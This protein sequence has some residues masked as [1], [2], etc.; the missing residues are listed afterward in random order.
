MKQH[1]RLAGFYILVEQYRGEQS[2]PFMEQL[3]K[4]SSQQFFSCS[5]GLTVIVASV[6]H[7]YCSTPVVQAASNDKAEE[8]E[9]A[10]LQTLFQSLSSNNNDVSI[11][12]IPSV[13]RCGLPYCSGS[14]WAIF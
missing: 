14:S 3:L 2:N 8:V 7:C 13:I 6:V 9:R 5:I 1:Q 4:V 12:Y 10:F 11:E